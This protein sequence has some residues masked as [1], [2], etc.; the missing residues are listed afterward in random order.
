MD[1]LKKFI[2][3]WALTLGTLSHAAPQPAVET[4]G[5]PFNNL[6]TNPGF[7]NGRASWV[8]NKIGLTQNR[9]VENS[10]IPNTQTIGA[11]NRSFT[12]AASTSLN[13][14][15][16]TVSFPRSYRNTTGYARVSAN[17]ASTGYWLRILSGDTLATSTFIAPGVSTFVY[18]GIPFKFGNSDSTITVQV[19][20]SANNAGAITLDDFYLGAS[21][22]VGL[23]GVTSDMANYWAVGN[24]TGGNADLGTSASADRDVTSATATLSV[25]ANSVP[26]GASSIGI[27]CDGSND[28]SVGATTCSAGN[29]NVGMI[30]N[31]PVAGSYQA[32]V[33]FS[34]YV[35]L[36]AS[37]DTT[38]QVT[39]Y[40]VETN[41]GSM[42]PT[43]RP[44][45]AQATKTESYN[46]VA[47]H[48]DH[49]F[50]ITLCSV[51]KFSTAGKKTIRLVYQ[52]TVSG[53]PTQN[54]VALDANNGSSPAVTGA[55]VS[56]RP[57]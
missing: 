44:Y 7:E 26:S 40:L 42:T 28:N 46:A 41:N 49:Y 22:A 34:H 23:T 31:I 53:T 17:T 39:F 11:G 51:F 35:E 10:F 27:P 32:C 24:I 55:T 4:Q 29:E 25:D 43:Q 6:L 16:Q 14:M 33:Q 2:T 50:P 36:P 12:W 54:S 19:Q 37:A 8:G 57:W 21:T 15:E 1:R 56:I 13:A 9:R 5:Q 52:Q 20:S 18:S 3:I 47:D 48:I 38:A 45:G 30:V